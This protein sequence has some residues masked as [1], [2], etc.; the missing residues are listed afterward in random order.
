MQSNFESTNNN[1]NSANNSLTQTAPKYNAQKEYIVSYFYK[2]HSITGI[3]PIDL[4]DL[5]KS[6]TGQL[7]SKIYLKEFTFHRCSFRGRY[8]FKN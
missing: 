1:F 7:E 6:R 2:F 5:D 8:Y 4:S 3:Y